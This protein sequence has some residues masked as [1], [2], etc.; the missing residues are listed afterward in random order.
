MAHA[1]QPEP[2]QPSLPRLPAQTYGPWKLQSLHL[3]VVMRGVQFSMFGQMFCTEHFDV[4][5]IDGAV[6]HWYP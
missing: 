6:P 2:S 1:K 4:Y 5:E 3:R